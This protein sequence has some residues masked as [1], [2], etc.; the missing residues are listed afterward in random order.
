MVWALSRGALRTYSGLMVIAGVLAIL[1]LAVSGANRLDQPYEC[2]AAHNGNVHLRGRRV[3]RTGFDREF[4]AALACLALLTVGLRSAWI[5]EV[6]RARQAD[7][8]S[9]YAA[10]DHVPEG[11]KVLP[12]DAATGAAPD[13]PIGRGSFRCPPTGISPPWPSCA[14]MLSSQSSSR[15]KESSR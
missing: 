11:S 4:Q 13:E 12:V 9:L 2:P 6:W 7:V 14:G 10:L 5:E 8:A 15:R 1:S 3:C